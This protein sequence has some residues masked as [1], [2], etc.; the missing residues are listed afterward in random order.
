VL[1]DPYRG[2]RRD[3]AAPAIA[4]ELERPAMLSLEPAGL[5]LVVHGT[6]ELRRLTERGIVGVD[7][8]HGEDRRERHLE[9]Q[10][11]AELLLG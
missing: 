3:D 1:E 11:V 10:E 4:V 7:F 6:D 8:D 5:G 2:R 9:G